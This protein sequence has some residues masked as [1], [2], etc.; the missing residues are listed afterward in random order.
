MRHEFHTIFGLGTHPMYG[1]GRQAHLFLVDTIPLRGAVFWRTAKLP[2]TAGTQVALRLPGNVVLDKVIRQY[3]PNHGTNS[4]PVRLFNR[5]GSSA[6]DWTG[7]PTVG[8]ANSP[9]NVAR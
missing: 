1:I 4:Y 7:H 2:C 8:L 9:D 5:A 3:T 6:W